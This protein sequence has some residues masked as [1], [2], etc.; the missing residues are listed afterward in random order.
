MAV[1]WQRLERVQCCRVVNRSEDKQRVVSRAR[2]GV[3]TVRQAKGASRRVHNPSRVAVL[4]AVRRHGPRNVV[5]AVTSAVK[6][7]AAYVSE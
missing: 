6:V 7:R 1:Q 2:G 3:L 5:L 4:V